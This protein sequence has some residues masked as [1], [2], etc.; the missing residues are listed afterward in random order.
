MS[1]VYVFNVTPK[2]IV[3]AFDPGSLVTGQIP[4][5]S[6]RTVPPWTPQSI[7]I[8]RVVVASVPPAIEFVD[9]EVNT[10]TVANPSWQSHPADLPIPEA[11]KSTDDLWLY[12]FFQWLLLLDSWGEPLAQIQLVWRS[13]SGAEEDAMAT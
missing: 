7:Q 12:V 10:I 11:P 2:P 9:G 13:A 5:V 1:Y 6:R 8:P 4:I 3:L